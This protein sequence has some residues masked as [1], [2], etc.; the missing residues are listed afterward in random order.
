MGSLAVQRV[1]KKVLQLDEKW[2]GC[3][4]EMRSLA[5]QRVHRWAH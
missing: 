5:V 1:L 2:L 3:W 4:W